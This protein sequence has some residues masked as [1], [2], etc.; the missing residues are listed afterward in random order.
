MQFASVTAAN[1][2]R[3]S[4]STVSLRNK[5]AKRL[6]VAYRFKGPD[7]RLTRGGLDITPQSDFMRP[8]GF[9]RLMI[10]DD[11]SLSTRQGRF[12]PANCGFNERT[13]FSWRK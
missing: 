3:V 9:G 6:F 12:R 10:P 5:A 11:E 8:I 13:K 1:A 7:G 4:T 2:R